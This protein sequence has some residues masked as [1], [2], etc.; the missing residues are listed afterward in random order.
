LANR[1]EST[2]GY[3][4]E[5]EGL[6]GLMALWVLLGHWAISVP[7]KLG[8]PDA[9]LY[10]GYAVD[11]F[12]MLSGFAIF[13]LLE[14][15]REAYGPYLIRRFLRIF[16]VYLFYLVIS[17]AIQPLMRQAFLAGPEAFMQDRRLEILD[18]TRAFWWPHLLA[19]IT[20]LHGLIPERWLPDT[21]F[22]FLGQAWSLSLEWQFYLIAPFLFHLIKGRYRIWAVAVPAVGILAA[23]ALRP[24]MGSGFLGAKFHLF[25][26]G[27]GTFYLMREMR[28]RKISV[29]SRS[30]IAI[31]A[32]VVGFLALFRSV[33]VLPFLVWAGAVYIGL[34]G[35]EMRDG[36]PAMPSRFLNSAPIQWLGHISYS[37]YLSHMILITA[38]LLVLERVPGIGGGAFAAALLLMVLPA[39][40]VLSSLSFML[41]ERPFMRIGSRSANRKAGDRAKAATAEPGAPATQLS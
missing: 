28:L 10:N 36:W 12:V 1:A 20:L 18:N 4:K 17:I 38:G 35:R 16:P 19:H 8:V 23:L 6:R 40:I 15:R 39:S 7:V 34:S 25:L 11:I 26:L 13:A 32:C 27:I 33:A 3:V 22:A 31:F 9:K 24:A 29:G 5:F 37:L 14:S 41:I 2:L 30:A 21:N